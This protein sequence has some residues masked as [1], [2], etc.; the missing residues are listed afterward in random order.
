[1]DPNQ[2]PPPQEEAEQEEEEEEEEG[3]QQ[4]ASDLD[5][6]E[7]NSDDTEVSVFICE[8]FVMSR[9]SPTQLSVACI[10]QSCMEVA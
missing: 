9:S 4:S 8:I 7:D 1:M 5:G 3:E 6:N 10:F 2:Q